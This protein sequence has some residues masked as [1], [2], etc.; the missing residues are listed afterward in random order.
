MQR[1]SY[2][3]FVFAMVLCGSPAMAQSPESANP[4]HSDPVDKFAQLDAWW[5]TPTE[6]R[7]ASGAPGPKYWQQQ[8]DY[9]IDVTLDDASQRLIGTVD[10]RYHNRSP[11]T[12]PYLWVQLD[13][14]RFRPDSDANLT[15][16]APSLSDRVS[17][18]AMKSL[19]AQET[20]DGGYKIAAVTNGKD[21]PL[22]YTIVG[23]M[24]RIDLPKPLGPGES[25]EAIIEY[26]YNIVD[27]KTIR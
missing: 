16:T 21:Q 10:L 13:Q 9:E 5:P 25:T 6:T 27:S 20:F 14:N 24:M 19:M 3:L 2:F 4:K 17:F 23:T 12:L 22:P 26:S 11:H 7:I 8:V 18:G 15:K 1:T